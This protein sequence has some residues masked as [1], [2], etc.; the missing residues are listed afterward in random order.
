MDEKKLGQADLTSKQR[1][2][3]GS[4]RF[5]SIGEDTEIFVAN[6]EEEMRD[7]YITMSG[8]G[9]LEEIKEHFEEITGDEL[10]KVIPYFDSDAGIT[11]QVSLR[12]L[13]TEYR[14]VPNQIATSYY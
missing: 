9:G 10:D 4:L 7:W 5:W 11:R 6:N 8:E 3:A 14:V 2:D 1:F 12:A 13:A